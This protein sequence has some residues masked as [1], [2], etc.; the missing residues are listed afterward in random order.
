MSAP[1]ATT[2]AASASPA[3]TSG[4]PAAPRQ[5]GRLPD[6]WAAEL[7]RAGGSFDARLDRFLARFHAE[8]VAARALKETIDAGNAAPRATDDF[9]KRMADIRTLLSGEGKDFVEGLE[10]RD[11]TL[12]NTVAGANTLELAHGIERLE[13]AVRAEEAS[14]RRGLDPREK[15]F[16]VGVPLPSSSA[17]P[18]VKTSIPP[19]TT[20]SSA[21]GASSVTAALQNLNSDETL[22]LMQ[23]DIHALKLELM[24]LQRAKTAGMPLAT[25]GVT[26]GGD[27]P[28]TA[29][30]GSPGK[31]T[32][33]GPAS[34]SLP[35]RG[36]HASGTGS[37][38]NLRKM[39]GLA[40]T[41]VA[42]KPAS[43]APSYVSHLEQMKSRLDALEKKP[44]SRTARR[45]SHARLGRTRTMGSLYDTPALSLSRDENVH[46]NVGA[47]TTP[48][49][50]VRKGEVA[51]PKSADAASSTAS[52]PSPAGVHKHGAPGSR[53]FIDGPEELL[54]RPQSY[55][56]TRDMQRYSLKVAR[57]FG[58]GDSNNASHA[59][60]ARVVEPRSKSAVTHSPRRRLSGLGLPPADHS[61]TLSALASG[62]G[63][64]ANGP[65]SMTE[66]TASAG[67]VVEEMEGDMWVRKGVLW[68]R[69][70]RRYASMV[71]H[72][73]FGR[74]LCLFSYDAA[75]GVNSSRSQI[76]VL[77]DGLCRGLRGP[78]EVGGVERYS[79]V[80]RTAAKEYY[81]AAET[82]ELRRSWVKELRE[83][84]RAENYRASKLPAMQPQR[85]AFFSKS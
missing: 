51:S 12:A 40:V 53:L 63:A 73:F 85:T 82:D 33:G 32:G 78:V 11:P 19:R 47:M 35:P 7:E 69:W 74:V 17:A 26:P 39:S 54:K 14:R 60:P 48:P 52:T 81:F 65:A 62:G 13:S 30:P 31:K 71:S 25:S 36:V 79:F 80:L 20:G 4:P 23:S 55:A 34:G 16:E 72:Q 84:A 83:A 27:M 70:R 22:Q 37:S 21:A 57:R 77:R 66:T 43:L 49:R 75:G 1:A 44:L 8:I 58:L 61:H 56:A 6:E 50:V 15:S 64:G 41:R 2:S 3:A 24:R 18:G 67:R 5:A 46:P 29:G 10:R 68:K 76:I 45:K 42:G 28:S 59:P 9:K 38:Q